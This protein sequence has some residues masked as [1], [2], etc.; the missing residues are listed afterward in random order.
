MF[1][2]NLIEIPLKLWLLLVAG[3]VFFLVGI[4]VT[5][6]LL[7]VRGVPVSDIP[8]QVTTFV[9]HILVGVLLSLLVIMATFSSQ[10]KEVWS[11]LDY[12]KVYQDALLGVLVGGLLAVAYIY[13]LAPLLE[14]LQRNFGDYVPTGSVLSVVSNNISLFFIANVI[15]APLVEETLYRGIAI[16]MSEAHIGVA[17]AV[18]L[19]CLFF[20]VLHWVGGIWYMLLTGIVAGG[21]FAGLYYYSGGIVAPFT[22]HFTLNLIEF[23]YAHHL[24]K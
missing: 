13:W 15:L 23:I 21:L 3:P 17:G 11:V 5:S 10:V 1:T 14:F 2:Q 8:D 9:S 18:A 12:G 24:Q 7:S 4:T 19:T 16:P 22:A 6:I 20:G